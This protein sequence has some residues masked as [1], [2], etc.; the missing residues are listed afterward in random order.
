MEPDELIALENDGWQALSAGPEAATAFYDRVLDHEVT[1]LLP[2]G[3]RLTDRAQ[4]LESMSGLPWASYELEDP[5]VVQLTP[6]SA[7]VVYVA[8]AQR[9]GAAHY[10]ALISSAYV[11]R[12]D[13]WKLALHQQTA[14]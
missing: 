14:R 9:E 8:V 6:D 13:G 7:I 10:S 11:R 4:I 1:M 2:G 5:R 12:D 3:L